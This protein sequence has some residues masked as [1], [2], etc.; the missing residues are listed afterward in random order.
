MLL[1][2]LCVGLAG[3]PVAVYPVALAAASSLVVYSASYQ[4]G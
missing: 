4:S 2:A 1:A 3:V